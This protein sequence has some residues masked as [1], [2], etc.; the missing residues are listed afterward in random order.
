LGMHQQRAK[1]KNR[2]P[3]QDAGGVHRNAPHH[4]VSSTVVRPGSALLAYSK[5][6]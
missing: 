1:R 3:K 6:W 2:D 5:S 4:A